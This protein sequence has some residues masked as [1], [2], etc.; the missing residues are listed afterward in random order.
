MRALAMLLFLCGAATAHDQYTPLKNPRT[1]TYCCNGS[2]CSP[3][4]PERVEQVP[5]GYM[6]DKKHF[7]PSNEVIPAKDGEYHACFW[8]GPDKLNCLLVP[9]A[10]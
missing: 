2:D 8:P 10:M 3:I 5:G 1:G 9:L 4:A 6:V 7:V